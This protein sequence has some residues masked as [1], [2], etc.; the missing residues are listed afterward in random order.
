MKTFTPTTETVKRGWHLLDAKEKVLGRL[1]SQAATYLLGKHK[2]DFAAHLD[3]GDHVII[4]NAE[5]IVTTG[6]KGLLKKYVRH[7]QYPGGLRVTN[8]KDMRATKPEFVVE[9]AVSGMLP[10]NKLK[11]SR[12]QRLHI[13][14]GEEHPY[15]QHV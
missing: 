5:K 8:L 1:A 3:T 15:G 12:M 14:I 9:H 7:S 6:T 10:D 13:V 2:S 11:K 4:I